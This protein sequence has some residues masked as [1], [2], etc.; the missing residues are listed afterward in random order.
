MAWTG[1]CSIFIHSCLTRL[2]LNGRSIKELISSFMFLV[3]QSVKLSASSIIQS[4]FSPWKYIFMWSRQIE[5]N[6]LNMIRMKYEPCHVGSNN[7]SF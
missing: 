3:W 2:V 6:Y 1:P 7:V 4:P 5:A